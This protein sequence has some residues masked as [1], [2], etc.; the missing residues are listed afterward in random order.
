MPA[1]ERKIIPIKFRIE[2]EKIC[3]T[4]TE[5]IPKMAAVIMSV[6]KRFKYSQLIK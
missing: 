1:S 2:I 4:K 6:V 5:Q 3:P